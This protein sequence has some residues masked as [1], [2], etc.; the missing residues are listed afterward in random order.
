MLKHIYKEELE[1]KTKKGS[2][3]TEKLEKKM[4]NRS[5]KRKLNE[6]NGKRAFHMASNNR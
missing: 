3:N 4:C 1:K 2:N 6:L 5:R